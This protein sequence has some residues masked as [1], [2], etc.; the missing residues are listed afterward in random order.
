MTLLSRLQSA[1]TILI[2]RTDAIGDN[3]LGSTLLPPLRAA[4]PAA[5]IVYACQ[6]RAAELFAGNPHIDQLLTLNRGRACADEGYRSEVVRT[7]AALNAEVLLNPVFSREPLSDNLAADSAMPVRIAFETTRNNSSY[8]DLL[9]PAAG[10]QHELSRVGDFLRGLGIE[11]AIPQPELN[12]SPT[13]DAFARE[14]FARHRLESQRA[15]AVYAG[16]LADYRINRNLGRALALAFP[17]GDMDI[18]CLGAAHEF[19][20]HEE[21]LADYPGRCINFCGRTTLL[22]TAAL[23]KRSRL[24]VGAETG[25]V[26]LACAVGTPNVAIVGGGH[27]ARFVPWSALMTT[28]CLPLACFRCDW[29]CK[30]SRHHCIAD[31]TAES[32]AT[33]I[34]EAASR[35]S[36]KPR[37]IV[38]PVD[39]SSPPTADIAAFI[40]VTQVEIVSP[41]RER[42]SP[43]G[44]QSADWPSA[45]R[46]SES[47]VPPADEFRVTAIVSTYAS[48][49]FMR[50][51]LEDLVAQSIFEKGQLEILVIDA[52]S[53]ENES[54]IVREFQEIHGTGRIR[55]HRTPARETLYASWNRA[56][57][58][59]RGTYLTNANTDD[60][61]HPEMLERL[62]EKLDH[63]LDAALAYCDSHITHDANTPWSRATRIRTPKLPEY[64]R[65]ALFADSFVGPHPM[66]RRSVHREVGYFDA[67]FISA[68]D[69]EFWLRLAARWKF[70]HVPDALGLCYENAQGISLGNMGLTWYEVSLARQ[71]YWKKE[72]G[73]DPSERALA[74]AF[75]D[76]T[77]RASALP[78]GARIALFG[79][80]QHTGRHLSKFREALE[81][82]S[83]IVAILDD[84]P[85]T[86]RT[87]AGIPIVQSDRW[88]TLA[89]DAIVVSSDTYET[90]LAT[91]TIKL[92]AGALP[93]FAVYK[94]NLDHRPARDPRAIAAA[95][96]V[97]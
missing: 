58:L 61:H 69:Y 67:A 77:R 16:A 68:G 51:C 17:A 33:G 70:V 57:D 62:A 84:R 63:E 18:L 23:L 43:L 25:A 26:H 14:L 2:L 65:E 11:T 50:G 30:Y 10:W 38:Q 20:L 92:T 66:W 24:A 39:A 32:I 19:T 56:V 86:V 87:L 27:F 79:A 55:Y 74:Q 36:A 8:T 22:Q 49:K 1:K 48:Q 40:D 89:L 13:D 29:Q 42:P 75:H 12:P 35:T 6:D 90:A 52:A 28:V 83:D 9:A 82:H 34:G 72:W 60:R 88:H 47:S 7:L 44:R 46:A 37:I 81:P 97:P 4:V 41:P 53:P 54:A 5:R 76:L 80:G 64:S 94:A 78:Q 45:K 3:V 21:L 95:V 15:I 71:R 73:A 93:V 91:R 31:I 85:Q 59:A 96:S